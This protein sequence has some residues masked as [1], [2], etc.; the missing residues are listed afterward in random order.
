[1][2]CAV[3]RTP[4]EVRDLLPGGGQSAWQAGARLQAFLAG[5]R[6]LPGPV[7][8]TDGGVMAE[9]LRTLLGEDALPPG[10]LATGIPPL[11]YRRAEPGRDHIR[12]T[13]AV[14]TWLMIMDFRPV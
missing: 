13:P 3:V 9:L 14:P 2:S 11:H 7:A 1:M 12:V 8:V 4:A 5:L 10:V 6:G